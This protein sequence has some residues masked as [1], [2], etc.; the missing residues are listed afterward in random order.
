MA[1]HIPTHLRL[2]ARQAAKGRR[3]L[4]GVRVGPD[5]VLEQWYYRQLRAIVDRIH[6][7]T[8]EKLTPILK[9]L[10]RIYGGDAKTPPTVEK[11][12]A[13]PV[14][15]GEKKQT[16][17]EINEIERAFAMQERQLAEAAASRAYAST[18]ERL[19]RQLIR[20]VGIDVHQLYNT[21]NRPKMNIFVERNVSLIKSIP[22][23]YFDRIEKT[24]I[25]NFTGGFRH[26][27][28]IK[29]LQN[30]Y[31]VTESRA[32]L[33]ARDQT[34][35]MNGEIA[36]D[37]MRDLGIDSYVWSTSLDERV[38]E[39]HME[40]E[41][42]QFSWDSPPEVGHP[43]QDYQCRC[44]AIP[45]LDLS[46]LGIESTTSAG[47]NFGVVG[48][49]DRAWRGQDYSPEQPRVPAGEPEGGEWTVSGTGGMGLHEGGHVGEIRVRSNA[50]AS[51][52]HAVAATIH[53]AGLRHA[54]EAHPIGLLH[55]TPKTFVTKGGELQESKSAGVYNRTDRSVQIKPT[56][57]EGSWGK[58]FT[59]GEIHSASHAAP[60]HDEAVA[61][62]MLHEIG[63][64]LY[65]QDTQ[66]KAQAERAF[67]SHEK[68]IVNGKERFKGARGF[69]KYAEKSAS[70]YMSEALVAYTYHPKELR[71]HDP[72]AFEL[73]QK[74]VSVR[75]LRTRDGGPGS[76]PRP[77]QGRIA[78]GETHEHFQD[79]IEHAIG[80]LRPREK[81]AHEDWKTTG[82]HA[83]RANPAHEHAKALEA[84][85]ARKEA[86]V[87]RTHGDLARGIPLNKED[88]E[89]I[90]P[91]AEWH[92]GKLSSWTTN[93]HKALEFAQPSS[94]FSPRS[95]VVFHAKSLPASIP[96]ARN[97][98]WEAEHLASAGSRFRVA[99]VTQ[100][101]DALHVHL[102]PLEARS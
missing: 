83:I 46:E 70:E 36:E 2:T 54:L 18:D 44:C 64:H 91:G 9:R 74:M 21:Q 55:F 98:G 90:K 15:E 69:T 72:K 8:L 87:G 13:R 5:L 41:G 31:D 60:S 29:D 39:T 19:S 37:R 49:D 20:A 10:D 71:A 33:I 61:R 30:D 35:K 53:R 85:I 59:P 1:L 27:A 26:E 101:K 89:K 40:L 93:P 76:G 99:R 51:L 68:E 66:L 79:R 57:A 17:H 95:P 96:I 84:Q 11:K 34:S 62:S 14:S 42:L 82:F 32:R 50:R 4:K 56:R 80:G 47:A 6:D 94:S 24:I 28:I 100:K 43:G 58:V 67:A 3:V 97:F 45:V 22:A 23:Q 78:K 81:A 48:G 86:T 63:H 25:D 38:R 65:H 75:G 88:I 77:G 52:R 73:A 12:K 16:I 92:E 7:L 102:E